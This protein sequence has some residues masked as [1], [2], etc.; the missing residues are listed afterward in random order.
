MRIACE[1][2]IRPV[3]QRTHSRGRLDNIVQNRAVGLEEAEKAQV[4]LG[5]DT[6]RRGLVGE[7]GLA[8]GTR[9]ATVERHVWGAE[10]GLALG[11]GRLHLGHTAHNQTLRQAPNGA[12]LLVA[13]KKSL[14]RRLELLDDEL[15]GLKVAQKLETVAERGPQRLEI[16]VERKRLYSVCWFIPGLVQEEG[17]AKVALQRV[18]HLDVAQ[19]RLHRVD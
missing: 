19:K 2:R 18:Q 9:R 7:K 10:R 12:C 13:D 1:D 6:E 15:A 14:H 5:E 3:G 8:I 4:V 11:R 17:G 16:E